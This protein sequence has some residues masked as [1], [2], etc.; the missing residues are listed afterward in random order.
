MLSLHDAIPML[1]SEKRR[2]IETVDDGL[3]S[4]RDLQRATIE[5]FLGEA[6]E[7][8][9]GDGDVPNLFAA[10]DPGSM[11]ARGRDRDPDGVLCREMMKRSSVPPSDVRRTDGGPRQGQRVARSE[12][13]TSELQSLMRNSYAVLCLKKKYIQ[14]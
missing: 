14:S 9:R 4:I 7:L 1:G 2:A 10:D 3:R 5:S 6:E 8:A 12:E 11:G 13:H